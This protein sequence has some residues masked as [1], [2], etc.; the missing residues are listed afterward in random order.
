MSAFELLYSVIE[1]GCE[2]CKD[3]MTAFSWS[4]QQHDL[5]KLK[6]SCSLCSDKEISGGL[7]N[8][9]QLS[10]AF[11]DNFSLNHSFFHP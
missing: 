6:K 2:G 1:K 10:F 3:Y 9:E 11:N 5:R 7:R 8:S 4:V